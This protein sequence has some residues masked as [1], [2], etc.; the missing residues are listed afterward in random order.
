M[1]SERDDREKWLRSEQDRF[2]EELIP[3]VRV[4]NSEE[5]IKKIEIA[6]ELG[7]ELEHLRTLNEIDRQI[8]ELR[9]ELEKGESTRRIELEKE[10]DRLLKDI[11]PSIDNKDLD[12]AIKQIKMA[13]EITEEL[14]KLGNG[15]LLQKIVDLENKKESEI[16][17]F[18]KDKTEEEVK[19]IEDTTEYLYSGEADKEISERFESLASATAE[20]YET[21]SV[22]PVSSDIST[23]FTILGM[24]CSVVGVVSLLLAPNIAVPLMGIGI[25]LLLL[26]EIAPRFIVRR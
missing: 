25:G 14:N 1:A 15:D 8:G 12:G 9:E 23:F 6:S 13:S 7:E 24:L 18:R 16:L 19:I 17:T 26:F 22:V 11:E 10:Q 4:G 3:L 5:A 2:L 21:R 20:K